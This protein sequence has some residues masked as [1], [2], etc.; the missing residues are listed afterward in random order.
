MMTSLLSAAASLRA[1]QSELDVL[2]NNIANINTPG[3]KAEQGQFQEM[4]VTTLRH[5]A[6]PQGAVGGRNPSQVGQGAGMTSVAR[7]FEDGSIRP[8]GRPL[9]LALAG[10]GFFVVGDGQREVYTRDGSFS[11]DAEG[12]LVTSA[13]RPVLGWNGPAAEPGS[14]LVPLEVPS[15]GVSPAQ[16]TQ[17]VV[18]A[19]N[20]NPALAQSAQA[21]T[22]LK[23]YDSLGQT[24]TVSVTFTRGS[25]TSWDWAAASP[26]GAVA[27]TGTLTFDAAGRLTEGATGALRLTLPSASQAEQ[28][29]QLSLAEVTQVAG[30]STVG[31]QSQDG[32]AAGTLRDV[33]VDSRGVLTG[34]YTNGLRRELGR[35]ALARFVNPEGLESLGGNLYAASA[36]SGQARS[37]A[38][39]EDASLQLVS[40]ALEMSNVDLSEEFTQMILAQRGFQA[41]AKVITTSDEVLQELMALKR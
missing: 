12:R 36:N 28:P 20:L 32:M 10:D 14:D 6:A 19:G 34:L 37:V 27:G 7:S 30:G 40:G 11:L 22:T 15:D 21:V 9:D 1:H 23:V 25:G 38:A 29:I 33:S 31:L 18:L 8:T 3:Y 16:A 17:R 5:A 41:N 39:G 24:H 13:G 26:D 2:G 35:V 4:L